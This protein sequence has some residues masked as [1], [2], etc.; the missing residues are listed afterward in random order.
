LQVQLSIGKNL[1]KMYI[2][3]IGLTIFCDEGSFFA[4]IT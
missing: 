1:Q 3:L 4:V 2:G